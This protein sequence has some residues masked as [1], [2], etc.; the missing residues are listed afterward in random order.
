MAAYDRELEVARQ[1]AIEAGALIKAAW[2][3]PRQ[4]DEKSSAADLVTETDKKCEGAIKKILVDAFPTYTFIG[5][6][7]TAALGRVPELTDAPSWLVDPVDGT[8]SFVHRFPFCCVS[9]ALAVERKVVAGI[10]Y[11]PVLDELYEAT[12]GGGARLNGEKILCSDAST[13]ASSIFIT[14]LGSRRDEE[15][16]DACF[17]RMRSIA[18]ATRG[19]RSCG[20]CALNLCSVASGRADGYY[21]IGLGGPWDMAAGALIL[22]EAGGKVSDPAGGPLNIMSRRVLGTNGRLHA[23]VCGHLETRTTGQRRARALIAIKIRCN[24][25]EQQKRSYCFRSRGCCP[26]Q[27]VGVSRCTESEGGRLCV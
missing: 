26:R 19:F 11:N 21:E 15:F 20:S 9:I 18:A 17:A 2:N 3:E 13:L 14:E 1:A 7:E 22:E 4:V 27:C 6:E 23:Q 10:V 24:S 12:A 25:Y 16:L 5:E 8:T